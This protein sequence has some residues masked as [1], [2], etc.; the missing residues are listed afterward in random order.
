M[1]IV[2]E[3]GQGTQH[4]AHNTQDTGQRGIQVLI[5]DLVVPGSEGGCSPV[6][7]SLTEERFYTVLQLGVE[8]QEVMKQ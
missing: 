2:S 7:R 6:I 5:K 4:T 8:I 3:L 1:A